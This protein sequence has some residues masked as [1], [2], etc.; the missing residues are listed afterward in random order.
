[1]ALDATGSF[2]RQFP[3]LFKNITPEGVKP[4]L[5]FASGGGPFVVNRDAIQHLPDEATDGV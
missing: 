5:L 1:M 2:S 4:A 3:R